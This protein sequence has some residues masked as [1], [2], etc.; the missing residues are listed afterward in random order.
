[1][2]SATLVLITAGLIAVDGD[3]MKFQDTGERLRLEMIDAPER[4]HSADCDSEAALAEIAT[5]RMAELLELGVI[6]EGGDRRGGYGRPLVVLRL[7]DGRSVGDV[8][9]AEGLAVP[10]AGRRQD[11][12]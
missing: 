5:V 1:M 12:C 4:G 11:W 9:I 6:I 2:T 7:S 8:L 10:C 3:T